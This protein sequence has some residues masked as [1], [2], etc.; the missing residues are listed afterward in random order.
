MAQSQDAL[1]EIRGL[2]RGLAPPILDEQG[3]AAAVTALAAR[4]SVPTVVDVAPVRLSGPARHAAYSVVAEA[5]TNVEK[6]SG[7]GRAAVDVRR[8]DGEVPAVAVTVTDD[9]IGG[10][11]TARGHGLAGLADRLAGVDGTLAISSPSGGPTQL[12]ALLPEQGQG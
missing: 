6:H 3:L 7:A 2:S 5:L 8:V 11:S 9:G 10:A 4:G 12:T 1:A